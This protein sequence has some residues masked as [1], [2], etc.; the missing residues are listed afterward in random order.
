[1]K[2]MLLTMVSLTLLGSVSFA[3]K[4]GGGMGQG[5]MGGGG[6]YSRGFCRSVSS[7]WG[8]VAQAM[9]SPGEYALN[10]GG[11]CLVQNSKHSYLM[12]NMPLVGA[13]G[14]SVGWQA[15]CHHPDNSPGAQA[16]AVVTCCPR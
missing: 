3:Q 4:F 1:M 10:G 5:N 2:S 16:R 8:N 7:N 13:N 6:A 9:C 11:E 15:D 14:L 12:Q